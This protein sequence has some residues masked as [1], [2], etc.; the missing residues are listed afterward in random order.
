MLFGQWLWVGHVEHSPQ[1]A[2]AHLGGWVAAGLVMAAGLPAI[3]VTLLRFDPTMVPI[4]LGTMSAAAALMRGAERPFPGALAGSLAAVM[5]I[6]LV[7]WW[8]WRALRRAQGSGLRAK[9]CG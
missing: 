5:V 1:P 4:V 2:G 7:A 3:Y 9:V 8:W 6:G